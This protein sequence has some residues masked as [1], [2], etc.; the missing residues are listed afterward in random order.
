MGLT[1]FHRRSLDIPHIQTE[2]GKYPGRFRG[3]LTVPHCHILWNIVNLNVGYIQEYSM[4]YC[5]SHITLLFDPN[6]VM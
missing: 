4:E 5:E 3:I 6:N 2:C 1:I